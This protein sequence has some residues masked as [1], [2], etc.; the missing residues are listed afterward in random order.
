MSDIGI[1]FFSRAELACQGSGVLRLHPAMPEALPRLRRA[2]GRALPVV[3]GCRSEAHNTAVRGAPN[4]RHR[5]DLRWRDG[6]IGT[7]AIDIRVTD[8]AFVH[9]II[10]AG[11][12]LGWSFGVANIRVKP[13]VHADLRTAVGDAAVVF[14]Y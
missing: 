10:T 12:P 7:L 3:S 5:F 11:L 8:A 6:S 9:H 1:D 4:S 13:I 14:G 2:V